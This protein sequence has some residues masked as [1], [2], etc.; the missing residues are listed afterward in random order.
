MDH[1]SLIHEVTQQLSSKFIPDPL[2]IKKRIENLIEVSKISKI[3]YYIYI[4]PLSPLLTYLPQREYLERCEDR[5]SYNYMVGGLCF[6]SSRKFKRESRFLRHKE[7]YYKYNSCI[8]MI[9]VSIYWENPHEELV[10]ARSVRV[11]LLEST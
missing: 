1:N 3:V 9:F 6:S 5:K 2:I 10:Y 4:C 11:I 8:L 7:R